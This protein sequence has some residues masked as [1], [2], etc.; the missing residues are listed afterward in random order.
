MKTEKSLYLVVK[1]MF[2]LRISYDVMK[3]QY[4]NWLNFCIMADSSMDNF[5]ITLKK[6]ALID[7]RG[8]D[9]KNPSLFCVF[10]NTEHKLPL[11]IYQM[12]HENDFYEDEKFVLYV[13]P[14]G[15][16]LKYKFCD[17]AGN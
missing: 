7:L 3:V 9:I 2:H 13:P 4:L 8:D 15:S 16:N 1:K 11:K 14:L 17:G 5:N 12:M 6:N 10:I